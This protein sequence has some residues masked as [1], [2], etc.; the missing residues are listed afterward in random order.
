VS[1]PHAVPFLNVVDPKFDFASPEVAQA[2]AASW[3]AHSPI[4]LLV[5][6]YTEA[7]EL[8]RD[9]RLDHNGKRFM[10]MYGIVDGPI[11]D[12]FVS[13]ISCHDG[14]SH[15]RLRGLVNKAFTPRTVSRLQPFIRAT[16]ERLIAR[17]RTV[18]T[19]EF[20]EDFANSLQ[21]AVMCQLLGVPEE[22]VETFRDWSTDLGSCSPSRTAGTS[23]PGWRPPSSG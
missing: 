6:R 2:Q 8:L 10:E 13:M 11:Y 17:L 5:L 3:Y 7:Q 14:A 1:A 22:D 21:L 23:R 12:W 9:P 16:A 15:R 18:E 4:G 20:V 19:C